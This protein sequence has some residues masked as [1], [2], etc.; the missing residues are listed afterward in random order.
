MLGSRPT[1]RCSG[2][3]ASVAPL[4][5]DV[6]P[7]RNNVWCSDVEY[8]STSG[9]RGHCQRRG[10]QGGLPVRAWPSAGRGHAVCLGVRL[11]R[12]HSADPEGSTGLCSSIHRAR[13]GSHRHSVSC[14]RTCRQRDEL[15]ALRRSRSRCSRHLAIAGWCQGRVVSR[16]RWQYTLSHRSFNVRPNPSLHP[17]C[18]GWLRQP[19]PAGELQR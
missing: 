3:T 5:G 11:K 12:H 8:C 6:E 7:H 2:R 15:P 9:V 16:P 19:P 18:Y 4:N 10:S 17:T 13:L 14:S 1:A